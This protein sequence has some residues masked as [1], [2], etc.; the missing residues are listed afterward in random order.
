MSAE[1]AVAG[2]R[3][4]KTVAGQ[5]GAIGAEFLKSRKDAGLAPIV[6]RF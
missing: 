6:K 1:I 5:N 3:L 4:P 2:K